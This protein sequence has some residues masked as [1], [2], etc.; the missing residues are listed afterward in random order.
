MVEAIQRLR[1]LFES[2]S[3]SSSAASGPVSSSNGTATGHPGFAASTEEAAAIATATNLAA[4]C[5]V[6]CAAWSLLGPCIFD[7]AIAPGVEERSATYCLPLVSPLH[8][9][10]TYM[11]ILPG[12][13]AEAMYAAQHGGSSPT[14]TVAFAGEFSG[15]ERNIYSYT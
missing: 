8:G 14:V 13:Y 15:L 7:G 4:G 2:S 6:Q 3:S 10:N 11:L 1:S 5:C 12:K 9:N